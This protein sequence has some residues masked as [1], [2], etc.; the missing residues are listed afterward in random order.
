MG[1]GVL[2]ARRTR[3]PPGRGGD[4]LAQL[5]ESLAAAGDDGHHRH[6]HQSA[7]FLVV[8]AQ[9]VLL[10][11]IDHVQGNDHGHA[12]FQRLRG[13]VEVAVEVGGIDDRHDHIGPGFPL[14]LP[15][16]DIH[17]HHLVGLRGARL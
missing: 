6:A 7:Q 11:D 4:G 3:L 14:L 2:A 10:G 13:Q 9:A 17:G 1:R 16:D 12:Q 8:D 5:I 15:Q